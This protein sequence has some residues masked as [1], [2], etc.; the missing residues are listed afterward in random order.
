M[1]EDSG[2]GI[3]E[4]E[5]QRITERFYRTEQA[6]TMV[7]GGT[8]LGLAI[9]SHIAL[10]HEAVL[11][12]KSTPGEGSQFIV[13]FPPNRVRKESSGVELLLH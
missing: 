6:R 13:T 7:P 2:I 3:C 10:R 8:G 5:L 1:V 12:I 9:V 4:Q 11:D